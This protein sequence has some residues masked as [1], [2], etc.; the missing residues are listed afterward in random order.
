MDKGKKYKL[1]M[2]LIIGGPIS[3][4]A[5]LFS[6]DLIKERNH[7]LYQK[8]ATPIEVGLALFTGIGVIILFI[9]YKE[10]CINEIEYKREK[11]IKATKDFYISQYQS[12][13]K[14]TIAKQIKDH[15]I[16]DKF[17]INE[18]I[19][20]SDGFQGFVASNN[21]FCQLFERLEQYI[22]VI[23]G[24]ITESTDMDELNKFAY[25]YF[26]KNSKKQ[27]G[28][29]PFY[30]VVICILQ[31]EVSMD[32]ARKV[33]EYFLSSTSAAITVIYETTTGKVFY[34][35]GQQW[36]RFIAFAR[37]QE[38]IKQYIIN[39]TLQNKI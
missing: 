6:L 23:N 9:F 4:L 30:R 36:K 28:H 1:H 20:F 29:L 15:L 14:E 25:E 11:V 31:D 22:F 7:I 32:I 37:T 13:E 19:F 12:L 5:I 18:N 27:N 26:V 16:Q 2:S 17:N 21:K 10:M 34:A 8:I 33:K 24:K 39:E 35:G 3:A 38:L